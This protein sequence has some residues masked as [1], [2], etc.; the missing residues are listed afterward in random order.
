MSKGL[1]FRA[2]RLSN[3]VSPDS[4]RTTGLK[5]QDG[6]IYNGSFAGVAR[7][8]EGCRTPGR[9]AREK[10]TKQRDSVPEC[11]SPWR[12]CSADSHRRKHKGLDLALLASPKFLSADWG[13]FPTPI[14]LVD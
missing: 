11:A 6:P 14:T 3:G 13:N 1:R 8:A 2:A 9:F 12:F 5:C 4:E 7:A 10:A